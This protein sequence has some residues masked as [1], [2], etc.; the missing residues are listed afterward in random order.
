MEKRA[1]REERAEHRR[2]KRRGGTTKDAGARERARNEEGGSGRAGPGRTGALRGE[3]NVGQ[4]DGSNGAIQRGA[5][6]DVGGGGGLG[7]RAG[8][9]LGNGARHALRC[10]LASDLPLVRNPCFI[11]VLHAILAYP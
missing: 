4:V 11:V 1:R 10:N 3:P 5:G 9:R 6:G 2:R 8:L 7:P